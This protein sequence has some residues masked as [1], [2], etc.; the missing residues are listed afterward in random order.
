MEPRLTGTLS[1]GNSDGCQTKQILS[2][3]ALELDSAVLAGVLGKCAFLRPIS[4]ATH[5]RLGEAPTNSALR[6]LCRRAAESPHSEKEIVSKPGQLS[7][8][9][10][11]PQAAASNNRTEGEYPAMT[12]SRRVTL[13]VKREEL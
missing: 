8:M 12:M 10:V 2:N 11:A 13:S 5:L 4:D 3:S 6:L 1:P 7:E 9:M